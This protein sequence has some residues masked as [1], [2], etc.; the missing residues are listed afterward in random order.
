VGRSIRTRVWS[1]VWCTLG[2]AIVCMPY[3]PRREGG[4]ERE[5]G[6]ARLTSAVGWGRLLLLLI[7]LLRLLL[8]GPSVLLSVCACG[9][10]LASRDT[11]G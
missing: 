6:R 10:G 3:A 8:H 4:R 2:G 9:R 11:T 7:M 1:R 5:G